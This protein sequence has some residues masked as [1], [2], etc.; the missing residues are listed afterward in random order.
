MH[1]TSRSLLV[2]VFRRAIQP[3]SILPPAFLIPSIS[4]IRAASFSSTPIPQARN[5]GNK[6]R[7]KDGNPN[8]GQSAL[9]RSG[10]ERG[11][12][13]PQKLQLQ[14]KVANLPKPVLDPRQRSAVQVDED[15]GLW[16]FF[17]RDRT[18]LTTP[19]ELAAHGRGWT[20]AELRRKDWDDIWRLWWVCIK[21]R[22]RLF[23]FLREKERVGKLF[24]TEEANAR[25]G[26]VSLDNHDGSSVSGQC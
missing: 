3:S 13:P 22:N 25:M 2:G 6:K 11:L 10:L 7:R 19:Q 20:V 26:Q 9:Y 12:Y 5:K 24:G 14:K 21:E 16:E 8:R 4:S 1:C 23:T 18:S 17:N 15:H